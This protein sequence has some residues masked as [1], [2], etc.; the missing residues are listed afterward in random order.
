MGWLLA[1]PQGWRTEVTGGGVRHGF[2]LRALVLAGSV[3]AIPQVAHA[4]TVSLDASRVENDTATLTINNHA[5]AWYYKYTVPSGDSSCTLVNA[6][7]STANLTSLLPG[8]SYTFKAYSDSSCSSANELTSDASDAE[9]LTKPGQ[10]KN[11]SVTVL[12]KSLK[13]SWTAMSGTVTGYRV[14]WRSDRDYQSGNEATPTGTSYTIP[15]LANGTAGPCLHHPGG[16]GERD[17]GRGLVDGS[18]RY[19]GRLD[20]RYSDDV[21]GV[22]GRRQGG[23]DVERTERRRLRHHG[24]RLSIQAKDR[25]WVDRVRREQH[26]HGNHQGDHRP[27]QRYN[28]PLPCPCGQQYW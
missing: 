21:I 11:V 14:Q 8:T 19:A 2:V 13:V 27:D 26:K 1:A 22:P 4:Q 10:A 23:L 18:H 5:T 7:T 24:L 9:F 12:N 17:G 20:P 16:S 15:N 28:I 25:P 6:N 3:F